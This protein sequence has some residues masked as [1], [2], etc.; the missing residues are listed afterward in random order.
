MIRLARALALTACALAAPTG[1]QGVPDCAAAVVAVVPAN[2]CALTEAEAL[3]PPAGLTMADARAA[4][5]VMN[6]GALF[7]V[8]A[9]GI[10]LRLVPDL[11]AADPGGDAAARAAARAADAPDD[12]MS[13]P[14]AVRLGLI[15]RAVTEGCTL[16]TADP[17]ALAAALAG[18][19]GDGADPATLVPPVAAVL[20]APG[21]D[22]TP[23]GGRLRLAPCTL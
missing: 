8:D 17:A 11:G 10:T 23:E 22:F 5:A 20:A 13:D 4:A 14:L 19:L 6:R 7:T 15:A 16:D 9:G 2:G 1:A 3:L 21:P 12:L 18:W